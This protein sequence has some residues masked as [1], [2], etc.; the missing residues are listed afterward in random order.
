MGKRLDIDQE[1]FAPDVIELNEKWNKM[2]DEEM[3]YCDECAEKGGYI[4][5]IFKS[6]GPC[7][8]CGKTRACN[9]RKVGAMK[10]D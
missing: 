3:F 6:V 5:S 10:A 4:I 1:G 7:E 8:L 2:R 9:N